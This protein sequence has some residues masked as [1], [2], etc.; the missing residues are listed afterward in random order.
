MG[1]RHRLA[2]FLVVALVIV[3]TLTAIFSYAYLR[4]SLVDKAKMELAAATRVFVGQLELLSEGVADDV[5]VLSLDYALRQAIAQ[6]DHETELSALRNHGR[7]VGATRMVLFDLDGSVSAD[8]GANA[9]FE[10][11][12]PIR[13]LLRDAAEFDQRTTVANVS[14]RIFW[15]IVVPVRAPVPIAFIAAFIPVDD[16]LLAKLRQVSSVPGAIALATKDRK[17]RWL[18]AASSTSERDIFRAGLRGPQPFGKT[19]LG[20]AGGKEYLTVSAKLNTIAGLSPVVAMLA[21]PLDD[22]LAP[23]WSM[24]WPML[25]VLAVALAAALVG[26][27]LIVR[28]VSRPLEALAEN[29]RQIASGDYTPPKRLAQQDEL[30]HLSDA[31]IAMARS[32]AECEEALTSAIASAEVARGE[33]ER[34]NLAKSQFLA[35]MSHELRTPLNAITGFGEMLHH[36]VL[37]PLGAKRYGEYA[38]DICAS[39]Q[40][41]LALVSKMLD[42][43]Q[44]E[45]GRLQIA[46]EGFPASELV[47]QCAA[48][49]VRMAERAGVGLSLRS[50]VDATDKILA[51]P[52]KLRQAVTGLIHNAVKFTPKGGT[53]V[54]ASTADHDALV[55][56]IEDTGIGMREEDIG[57]VTRPFHRLRSALDGQHQGAGLGLP[58]AKSIVDL[59]GGHLVLK[60][61]LGAGTVVE[62]RLPL[63]HDDKARAA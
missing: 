46:V 25:G 5:K 58:F 21:Y 41:L 56:R 55:V 39:A 20:T 33:A 18:T 38:G 43:S 51:D 10:R 8:T 13:A 22:A 7:R 35:N 40:H 28:G 17:G 60:S 48:P 19:E 26:A 31:L 61:T 37:G 12:F 57:L 44:A 15:I 49:V 59:H 27:M 2:L 3:Q 30:G 29:A 34:A 62:I 14:G 63:L 4:H 54:V 24:V 36:E 9:P 53:V 42:L 1:F 16:A 50:Q 45:A 52:A 32:I 23:Y 6:H 11:T 47:Q